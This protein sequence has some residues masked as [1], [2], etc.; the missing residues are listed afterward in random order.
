MVPI[1][2]QLSAVKEYIEQIRDMLDDARGAFLSSKVAI[3]RD[4]LHEIL[5]G[6]LIIVEDMQHSMPLEIQKAR[7]I[8]D[9]HDKIINEARSK[10]EKYKNLA[11]EQAA[12]LTDEHEIT[13]RANEKAAEI[14]DEAKRSAREM[15]V[16]SLEYADEILENSEATLREAL[17]MLS[18][19][20]NAI[21]STFT[22]TADVLFNNRQELRRS[23][24]SNKN[25]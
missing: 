22:E 3:D 19:R 10:A 24:G 9:D 5:D 16:T 4:E 14:M 7:Q 20:Y 2:K 13:R 8:A 25:E 12:Q 21:L 18:K 15:R 11:A 6:I 23:G 1:T 17:D